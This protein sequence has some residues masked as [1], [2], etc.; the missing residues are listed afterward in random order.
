LK[1]RILADSGKKNDAIAT[2][3][4]AIEVGKKANPNANVTQAEDL[5]KEWKK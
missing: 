1:A 3:Q 5:I 4:R 2:A